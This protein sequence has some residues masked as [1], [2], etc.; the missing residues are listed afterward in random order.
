MCPTSPLVSIVAC[1]PSPSVIELGDGMEVM[2]NRYGLN[3]HTR[4]RIPS[5]SVSY[6]STLANRPVEWDG[7]FMDLPAAGGQMAYF[8][9]LSRPY[10]AGIEDGVWLRP[11]AVV[12]DK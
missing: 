1:T 3:Q 4:Y 11:F 9:F 12:E 5:S 10:G 6:C 2:M 8:R 7:R